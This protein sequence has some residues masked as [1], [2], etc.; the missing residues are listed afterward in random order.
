MPWQNIVLLLINLVHAVV[1]LKVRNI[2]IFV[3]IS[4]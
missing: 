1:Y 2:K 3:S 4:E